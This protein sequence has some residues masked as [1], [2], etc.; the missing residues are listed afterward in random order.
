M[1]DDLGKVI[2]FLIDQAGR[3]A[4]QYSQREFDRLKLGITVDQWVLLK[5]IE[6]NDQ[7][8][9]AELAKESLR[10][11]ASITRTLD[12]LEK[13]ELA[14]RVS[15]EGNRRQYTLMLTKK[16]RQF[17]SENMELIRKHRDKSITGLTKKELKDLA[18]ML[19]RIKQNMS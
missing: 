15:I 8:S 4:K 7:L 12:L 2:L 14:S 18:S 13:K 11:P 6:Q 5:I 3:A 19:I 1:K 10:D 9:Q 16:G 17:I